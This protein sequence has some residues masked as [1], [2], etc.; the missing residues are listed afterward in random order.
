MESKQHNNQH[1]PDRLEI[2]YQGIMWSFVGAL[3]AAIFIPVFEVV[4]NVSPL[5]IAA[6][7]ATLAATAGG[8]LVYSSSQLALLVALS[9]NFAVFGYLLYSGEIASPLAPMSVGACIGAVV[10][11][12]YGQF[13]KES[14]I[15]RAEAILLAGV[16]VGAVVSLISLIWTLVF[17]ASLTVLVMVLAPVSGLIYER[18][19][20]GFIQRYS[21]ILPPAADG[22]VAGIVIG[23]L[24][25]FGLWF[26]GGI[27]LENA[28]L[29]WR[30]TIQKIADSTHIAIAA[31][32]ASTLILGMLNAAIRSKYRGA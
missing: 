13:V 4:Q 3:Y 32:A 23:G 11:G 19:V 14:R 9:S 15:Y 25:G 20:D 1:K 30:D 12:L 17:N 7:C 27:A 5:W 10:G 24:I 31:A 22:A 8:A 29:Q 28:S 18:I 6:I 16:S 2:F 26:M 21:D